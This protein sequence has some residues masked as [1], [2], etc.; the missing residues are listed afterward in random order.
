MGVPCPDP[1][2]GASA[3]VALQQSSIFSTGKIYCARPTVEREHS[4][5]GALTGDRA[6]RGAQGKARISAQEI[7]CTVPSFG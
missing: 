7:R 4:P 1:G 6:D 2:M 3:R 5:A